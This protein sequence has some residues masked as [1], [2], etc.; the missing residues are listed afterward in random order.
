MHWEWRPN[1]YDDNGFSVGIG[2]VLAGI[3]WLLLLFIDETGWSIGAGAVFSVC[4]AIDILAWLAT[5]TEG[6]EE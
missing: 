3:G 2:T 6:D 4:L 1:P 5:R